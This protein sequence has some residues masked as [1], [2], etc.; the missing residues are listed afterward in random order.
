MTKEETIN[1]IAKD[2]CS[3]YKICTCTSRDG[4]CSTPQQHARILYDLNYRKQIEAEWTPIKQYSEKWGVETINYYRCS[5][6]DNFQY[7]NNANYCP[8]CGAKM[9]E[10][11]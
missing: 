2:L 7:T 8:K 4:H 11:R 6:C 3:Q 5:N 10:R 9:I 1:E